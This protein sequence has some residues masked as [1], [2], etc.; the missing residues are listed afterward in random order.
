MSSKF[1]VT[2]DLINNMANTTALTLILE[3]KGI[4]SS[5]DFYKAKQ[6]AIDGIREEYSDLFKEDD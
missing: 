5:E 1:D 3:S 4:I 6:K 2:E